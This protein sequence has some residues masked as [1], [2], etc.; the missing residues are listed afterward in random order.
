MFGPLLFLIPLSFR[1]VNLPWTNSTIGYSVKKCILHSFAVNFQ[2]RQA[3][4]QFQS[5]LLIRPK[6]L[7]AFGSGETVLRLVGGGATFCLRGR[8]SQRLDGPYAVWMD[9]AEF[10]VKRNL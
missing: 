5:S 10:F 6:L 1:K 7:V 3:L 9:R 4:E 8:L 2:L